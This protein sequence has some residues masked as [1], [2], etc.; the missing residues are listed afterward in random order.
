MIVTQEIL[1]QGLSAKGG[2]NKAQLKALLPEW[3]FDD[4]TFGVKSGWKRRILN[5]RR[6]ESKVKDFLR[7]KDKAQGDLFKGKE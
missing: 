1:E 6:P 2:Y 5:A 4:S 7:L 3:E